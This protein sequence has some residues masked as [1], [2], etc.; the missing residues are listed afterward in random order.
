MNEGTDAP[1]LLYVSHV[2][3]VVRIV[4][5]H[6][7]ALRALGFRVE[8]ACSLTRHAEE[9]YAHADAVHDLPFRRSP[10]DPSNLAALRLLTDLIRR[11]RYLVVHSQTPSGGVIGRLAATR[12]RVPL[13]LYTAHGFHFHP[14]GGKLGNALFRGIETL[15]GR[16]WSDGVMTVNQWD[17]EA[18]RKYRLTGRDRIYKVRGTGVDTHRF[19]PATV[20][21]AER[22]AFRQEMGAAED[23]LL[24]TYIAEMIPRKRH[25]DAL[26]AFARLQARHPNAVLA[27]L[28]DGRLMEELRSLAQTLG[29]SEKTRFSGFRRDVATALAASDVFLFPS[30][31][32]GL[33]CAI[34]EAMSMAL[35]VVAADVRGS[36]D[37]IV[38]GE[39][40]YLVP[41]GDTEA[42]G[43]RL[44]ELAALGPQKRALLGQAARERMQR[45]FSTE[46]SVAEWIAVYEELCRKHQIPLPSVREPVPVGELK[47]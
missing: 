35:P 14:C 46:R 16:Y 31:Q 47:R 25:A 42:M 22:R 29:V 18:A 32:E 44:I 43:D 2:D 8:V 33:P 34:M 38:N 39:C 5:P 28:G 13:R 26:A 24:V 1:K 45:E 36:R 19:D 37:L 21:D 15:A 4:T 30:Q 41:V 3:T 9:I 17:F 23:N 27:L 7:D 11:E 40:G 12:A 20:A 6:L 10:L